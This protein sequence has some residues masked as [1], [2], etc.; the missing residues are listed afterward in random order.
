M[1]THE[2]GGHVAPRSMAWRWWHSG[3]STRKA[4]ALFLALLLLTSTGGLASRGGFALPDPS[5]E[6]VQMLDN[7]GFEQAV[8]EDALGAFWLTPLE[9]GRLGIPTHLVSEERARTGRYALRLASPRERVHQYVPALEARGDRLTISA[10]VYL[11]A[12]PDG[13]ASGTLSVTDS[14]GNELTYVLAEQPR[15]AGNAPGKVHLAVPIPS[16]SWQDV[17]LEFGRDYVDRFGAK[18][19]PR[20][21][22]ALGKQDSGS[23]PVYWDDLRAQGAFRQVSEAQLLEAILTEAR[24][25][26]DNLLERT[27]D[28]IGTPSPYLIKSL[29]AIT[30]EVLNVKIAGG[31]GPVYNQ[32]LAVLEVVSDDAY[33]HR[34]VEMADSMVEHLHPM[35]RL[36]RKYDGVADVPVDGKTIPAPTIEFLLRVYGLTADERYLDAATEI[37]EAILEFAP[38]LASRSRS[39]GQLPRDYLPNAYDSATGDPLEP[40]STYE[41]HIRW[42]ASPGALLHLYSATGRTDFKDAAI[43]SALSYIDHDTILHYWGEDYRLAPFSFEPTWY[44]WDRIDP[45]FDDYFGYG[46][47]GRRGPYAVLDIYERTEDAR[48]LPFL[49]ASMGFMASVWEEG[50]HRGGYTFADDARSWQAY[51]DRYVAHPVRYAPYKELLLLNA[52]NVFRASQ[53]SNGAWIDARF[54]LWDPSF[55][56]DRASCPRNLLAALTWAYLVDDRDPQWRAMIASVFETTV[57]EYKRDYGYLISP[58][59]P[60]PG[61]NP[62]GIELRFL[63]EL[64]HH[65][66]PHLAPGAAVSASSCVGR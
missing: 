51:Y 50:I 5:V 37:G 36:P 59:G 9:R 38:R 57:W 42:F 20:L 4:A 48:L 18:P 40:E 6:I 33:Y 43:A 21:T 2:R 46:I 19:L 58:D 26:I 63:G 23:A 54:R 3:A 45:A 41:M 66:V 61:Q 22:L 8:P 27:M 11:T 16:G 29:D 47:G 44:D 1:G 49:D 28:D 30:G 15:I 39:I 7:G 60:Q 52:R 35:T 62:G 34:V 13:A 14:R 64:L 17:I 32:M 31:G 24:W 56:D 25:T 65:L 55:P 53:Y 12:Q 10:S